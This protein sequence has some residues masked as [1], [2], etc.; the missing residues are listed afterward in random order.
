MSLSENA[1]VTVCLCTKLGRGEQAPAL[2]VGEWTDLVRLL[3][4]DRNAAPRD[5]L[6]KDA[7]E[8]ERQFAIEPA[9]AT[10]IESLLRGLGSAGIEIER[11]DAIG[12]WILTRGD[13]EYPRAWKRRLGPAA[14]PVIFGAGRQ[15]VLS[16]DVIAIAG[17]RNDLA[18]ELAQLCAHDGWPVVTDGAVEI[19]NGLEILPDSLERSIARKSKREGIRA[20]RLTLLSPALPGMRTPIAE[21][22]SLAHALAQHSFTVERG[23]LSYEGSPID[24]PLPAT[25]RELV[26]V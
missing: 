19:A 10:R 13:A 8:L 5:L 6:G 26:A 2:D 17:L 20:G 14:P 11:L 16:A 25:L 15:E 22:R 23:V 9:L 18:Q 12:V 1:L 21:C 24:A 3:T 7:T 4:G